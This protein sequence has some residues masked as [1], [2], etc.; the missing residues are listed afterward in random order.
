MR[1][2]LLAFGAGI[3]ITLIT[4]YTQRDPSPEEIYQ[5]ANYV[6][7]IEI[8]Q[9]YQPKANQP[10]LVHLGFGSGSIFPCDKYRY[11]VLTANHI[12]NNSSNLYHAYFKDGTPP[13]KLE[14]LGGATAYDMTILTFTNPQFQPKTVASLGRS[15]TLLAGSKI[16][17]IGSNSF[18]DF[19]FSASGYVYTPPQ[20]PPARLGPYWLD[21]K[22]IILAEIRG[23][24]GYSGGPFLN[25][26]GELVGIVTG[27]QW[28]DDQIITIGIPIDE[29]L[30]EAEKIIQNQKP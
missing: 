15:Q 4:I 3:V 13:Q 25:A 12:A 7:K 16:M 11:C 27:Y 6:V 14:L 8:L 21:R 20:P 24:G 18:G 30:I 29:I 5:N 1:K 2:M 26:K 28:L 9:P 10:L 23:F 19:W 22:K 17:A